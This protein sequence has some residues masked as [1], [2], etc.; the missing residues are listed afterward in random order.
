MFCEGRTPRVCAHD[1]LVFVPDTSIPRLG[2]EREQFGKGRGGELEAGN[3]Y[4]SI[5]RHDTATGISRP[6]VCHRL[7]FLSALHLLF[8]LRDAPRFATSTPLPYP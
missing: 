5:Q 8:V 2:R 1:T 6:Q 7:V 3:K 4:I